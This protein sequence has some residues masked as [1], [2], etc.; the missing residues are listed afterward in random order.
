[1]TKLIIFITVFFLGIVIAEAQNN[2][3]QQNQQQGQQQQGPRQPDMQKDTVPLFA[4]HFAGPIKLEDLLKTDSLF[5]N[6]PG[7][8]IAQFKLVFKKDTTQKD[9][10]IVRLKSTSNKFTPE[11]KAAVKTLGPGQNVFIENIKIQGKEG[12]SRSLVFDRIMLFIE[13]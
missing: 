5:T 3:N 12:T 4:G 7:V 2:N 9:T 10:N 6:K 13:K 8:Q 11:M 1:M